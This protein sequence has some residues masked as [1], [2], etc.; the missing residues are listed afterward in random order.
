MKR[1]LAP[2]L[3]TAA[4]FA[5]TLL[6]QGNTLVMQ[7]YE[8]LFLTTPDYL[9]WV[10]AQSFPLSQW[11]SDFLTQFYRLG[12]WGP[13]LVA[14]Q[15]LAAYFLGKGLWPK[16]DV[17]GVA[18]ACAEW[19]LI[20]FSATA[21]P[22]IVLLWGLLLLWGLSRV[23]RIRRALPDKWNY[24]VAAALVALCALVVALSPGLSR[25][26]RWARVKRDVVL[27]RWDDVLRAAPPSAAQQDHEL[28]AFALL[29]LGEQQRLGVE[30]FRYPV[31]EE[32][33]LDL[34]LEDDYTNSIFYRAFLY[35][36]LGCYNESCHQLFQLATQQQHGTSAMVLRSLVGEYFRLGNFVL[37]E[38][39]CKILETSSTHAEFVRTYRRFMAQGAPAGPDTPAERMQMDLIT[40][41]PAYNLIMLED[42]DIAGPST[43]DRLLATLLLQRR[44]DVFFAFITP[45]LNR[46]GFVL[47]R[48]YAEA[49]QVHYQENGLLFDTNLSFLPQQQAEAF[50]DFVSGIDRLSPQE[51]E[52]RYGNTY[53]F[54]YYYR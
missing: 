15:V 54:Y 13:V 11:L 24:S 25:R 41:N 26:E 30:M 3:V 32:N 20:A 51:Q 7:E 45:E 8:G 34:C 2:C 44:L 6:F 48:H 10:K 46:E 27:S 43:T 5:V 36:N 52:A 37:A 23:V 35:H 53:W 39:Y 4:C 42:N 16:A 49:L 19:L 47:P 38:K 1:I 12:W 29:A 9:S 33:D 21:K 31:Y 28:T 14:L 17:S 40:R 18:A 22:G 50:H